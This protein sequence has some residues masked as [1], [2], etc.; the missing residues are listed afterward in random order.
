M[1][2]PRPLF[3]LLTA[4]LASP[5][6][7]EPFEG[8]LPAA[9][10]GGRGGVLT[11]GPG[12]NGPAT[13]FGGR[14][15]LTHARLQD[16][17]FTSVG[18]ALVID[19]RVELGA[20]QPNLGMGSSDDV[21][22]N[23]FGARLRL[24][25]SAHRPLAPAASIGVSYRRQSDFG[26][27]GSLGSAAPERRNDWDALVSV[28]AGHRLGARQAILVHGGARWTRANAGGLFG[29]GGT[30]GDRHSLQLEGAV[31][32]GLARRLHLSAEYRQQPDHLEDDPGD[33]WWTA[34]LGYATTPEVHLSVGWMDLGRMAG[35]TRQDGP[36]ISLRGGF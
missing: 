10:D 31:H 22:Q 27:E 13:G 1:P 7:A 6:A 32:A 23:V 33:A 5:L 12:L 28:G 9:M 34:Y 4:L 16:Q 3:A 14:A 2:R 30:D 35:A 29:F 17:Q 21:R 19:D 18:A 25:G 11:P 20:S 24:A 8:G 15:F 26:L 36:F